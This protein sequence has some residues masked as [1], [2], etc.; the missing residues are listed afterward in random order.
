MQNGEGFSK[1]LRLLRRSDFVRLSDSTTVVA[2]RFFLVVWQTN[3]CGWPRVGVTASK[4]TGNAVVRNRLKRLVR[5]FFRQ[6]RTLLPAVDL[7]VIARRQAAD[8]ST[9]VLIDEL[10]RAFQQIGSSTCCHD[11]L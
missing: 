8:T 5:E 9:A 6:Q 11:C 1:Q 4:R 3:E 10:K 7:N 2:G